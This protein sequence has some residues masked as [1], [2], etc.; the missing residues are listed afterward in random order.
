MKN[1]LYAIL[2]LPLMLSCSSPD[3]KAEQNIAIVEKYV[4]SVENLDYQ[5]ME[6]LLHDDYLG[7]GPSYGDSINKETAVTNW[8]YLVDNLYKSISYSRSRNVAVTINSGD[9]QGDW[10]SN[11]GELTIRYK[12]TDDAVT[13]W[14][15]SIY[16]IEDGKII[17]SFTFYNEADA[18]RQLGYYFS[19]NR[20]IY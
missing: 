12:N 10:V 16:Q 7:M 5:T 17:K 2:T 19:K 6:L 4:Q 20:F 11:W 8:E 14:A 3:K 9:N 1:L 15:N 18:L 13:I